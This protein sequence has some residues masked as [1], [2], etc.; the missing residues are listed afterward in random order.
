MVADALSRVSLEDNEPDV[1]AA[2]EGVMTSVIDYAAMAVQQGADAGIQR[3]VSDPNCSLQLTRCALP[4]TNERLLVDMSTGRPRPLVP[5]VL[6]RTI[7]DANHKLYHAGARAMRRLICDRFVWPGMSKDIR[8]WTR[9]CLSCQRAK[10]TIHAR[11]PI[12]PLPMPSSRFES[13][14]VDLVGP[15]PLSQGFSYL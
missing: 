15:L 6:T 2:M 5:A 9:S 4:D 1:I 14:H 8:Q 10:V 11:A 3:V 12:E 13:L 7:F